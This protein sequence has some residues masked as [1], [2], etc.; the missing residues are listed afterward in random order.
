MKE[1]VAPNNVGKFVVTQTPGSGKA[2]S[3]AYTFDDGSAV[4]GT[5]YTATGGK[6]GVLDFP[7]NDNP[8]ATVTLEL[9]FSVIADTLDENDEMFTVTLS[10]PNPAADGSIDTSNNNHIGTA[11]IIDD[12]AMPEL[13][14]AD[15]TVTEGNFGQTVKIEFEPILNTAS[16][17]DVIVSYST[18]H[19]GLFPTDNNDF[20]SVSDQIRIPAGQTTSADPIRITIRP[21]AFAEPDETF[22]LNF[23]ADFAG[24]AGGTKASG[25]IISDDATMVAIPNVSVNEGVGKFRLPLFVFPAQSGPTFIRFIT[26]SSAGNNFTATSSPTG[27]NVDFTQ[28]TEFTTVN[29]SAGQTENYYEI[30]ITDDDEVEDS[31]TFGVRYA[32]AGGV[33]RY[34]NWAVIT[35]IDNETKPEVDLVAPNSPISEGTNENTNTTHN[36]TVSIKGGD[37]ATSD[38]DVDYTLTE[39]ADQA[40]IPLDVKLKSNAPGRTSDSAGRVRIASGSNSA[41]IPLEI[42][43]DNYDEINEQFRLTL[44]NPSGAI[45]GTDTIDLTISDD[46][47]EPKVAIIATVQ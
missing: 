4:E 19:G 18:T 25:K 36:I 20:N 39:I 46:D 1:G 24:T 47:D 37:N 31:E 13:T 38:I 30:N 7:A 28:L 9:P 17:R 26:N 8:G 3:V 21:D 32:G 27:E 33:S 6:T 10:K 41:T 12:D 40:D 35:I 43:A 34:S 29:F 44:S 15:S 16:G 11:T 42:I 45:L 22:D 5:D 2:I 14:I 23:S